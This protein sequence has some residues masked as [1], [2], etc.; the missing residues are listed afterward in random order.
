MAISYGGPR[1]AKECRGKKQEG[2]R[3]TPGGNSKQFKSSNE[4]AIINWHYKKQQTL[5]F[6]GRDAPSLR[7]KLMDL[8]QKKPG[9]TMDLQDPDPSV[10]TEQTKQPSLLRA[11]NSS[12][13]RNSRILINDERPTIYSQ[14]RSNLEIFL[15]LQK[16]IEENTRLLSTI[17]AQK[18]DENASCTELLDCKTRCETL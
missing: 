18:Q 8:V 4:N 9:P 13:E 3:L 2:K 11:A 10:S 16:Q 14:E 1:I 5:S 17:N 15:I 12:Q 6:Q 7:D